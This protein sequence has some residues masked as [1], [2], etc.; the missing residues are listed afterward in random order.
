MRKCGGK[1]RIIEI[2]DKEQDL[3]YKDGVFPNG[4]L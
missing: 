2:K 4:R 1:K 3:L